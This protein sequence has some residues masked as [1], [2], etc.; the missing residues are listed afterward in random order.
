M[1]NRDEEFGVGGAVAYESPSNRAETRRNTVSVVRDAY[2]F[3]FETKPYWKFRFLGSP[4]S[5]ERIITEWEIPANFRLKMLQ[6]NDP[7]PSAWS[8]EKKKV[9]H[10]V[11][12]L[13]GQMVVD[14]CRY[15]VL[16]TYEYW[17]FCMRTDA[18]HFH[19]SQ[20][21]A[22][23]AESPSVLQALV[24]LLRLQD[25]RLHTSAVH[26]QS[27]QKPRAPPP[28]KRKLP[29]L[30]PGPEDDG[31]GKLPPSG[32]R[33]GGEESTGENIAG[34]LEATDCEVYDV[35]T[36]VSLLATPLY[37]NVLIKMQK[38]G[39]HHVV[40]EMEREAKMYVQL[41]ENEKVAR[42]I[43][44]FFGFSKHWGVPIL[45]L[46]KEGDDF[47]DLG[48]QNLSLVVRQ[49]A[50]SAVQVLSDAGV[51]HNDLA[52]RNFVVARE[53][54]NAAKIIDFGRTSFSSDQDLLQEQVKQ[55][56]RILEIVG[57]SIQ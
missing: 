14:K 47:D 43:P 30:P 35:A 53:D 28:K 10:V 38:R 45:C 33:T 44:T 22:K 41:Q 12:Q 57:E 23:E 50:L 19:I 4:T 49:S 34:L 39:L 18:G 11:R 37:P 6:E 15:G 27:A 32:N 2:K 25:Y 40:S 48:L 56:K 17:F 36:N 26:P 21:Y 52:L 16:H 20:G 5:S 24:T 9:F 46:E 42:V 3:P 7:L 54:S 8:A 29:P 13:Y 1:E 31:G 51:L 55:A